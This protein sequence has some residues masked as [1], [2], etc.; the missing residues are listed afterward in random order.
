MIGQ[1]KTL[2]TAIIALAIAIA[3]AAGIGYTAG[4]TKSGKMI[5]AGDMKWQK[6][7]DGPLMMVAL[8]GDHSKG[9]SGRLLKLPA[10]FAA[11]KHS[12]TG[13]Y[14][15]ILLSG[16]WKHTFKDGTSKDL[17]AGSYVYQPGKIN[18]DDE[19]VSKEPCVI[20]L[21]QPVASDFIPAEMHKD[22]K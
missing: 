15:A 18:H 4:T 22:K 11:P 14:H 8:W 20:F 16:T 9:A 5:A 21:T 19:C 13:D 12:H 7:G 17:P 2:K 1:N 6:I 10:G 3:I